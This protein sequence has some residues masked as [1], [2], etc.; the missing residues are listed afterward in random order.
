M[1][2]MKC[3]SG[4]MVYLPSSD[5]S[6][7]HIYEL[8]QPGVQKNHRRSVLVREEQLPNCTKAVFEYCW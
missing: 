7:R 1:I 2:R 6:Q 4:C 5:A 8:R 3:V